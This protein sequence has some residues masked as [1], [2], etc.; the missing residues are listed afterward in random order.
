MASLIADGHHL[1][2]ALLKTLVRAKTPE[3]CILISDISGQAGQPPGFYRS[4][5]CD[6]EL[7][8]NGRLVVAGQRELLA[9]ASM[10]IGAGVANVMHWAEVDLSSAIQ[11][12][13]H[14]PARLL[15]FEPDGLQ[16]GSAADLVLF[17]LVDSPEGAGPARFQVRATLVQGDVVFGAIGPSN[18]H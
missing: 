8:P 4:P 3:R 12:V 6:V 14:R 17:D 5:F 13:V 10:P 1:P 11:M 9:G 2:P 7:L 18:K 16:P 15:G